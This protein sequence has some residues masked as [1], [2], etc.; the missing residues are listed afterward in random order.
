MKNSKMILLTSIFFYSAASF[1]ASYEELGKA[2]NDGDVELVKTIVSSGIDINPEC[3]S[4]VICRPIAWAVLSNNLDVIIALHELGADPNGENA[5]GDTSLHYV[6]EEGFFDLL[7][8]LMRLGG[9]INKPNSFGISPFLAIVNAGYFEIV[10]FLVSN[11][12]DIN[13]AH[14]NLTSSNMASYY[15][16]LMVAALNGHEDVVRLLIENGANP[17]LKNS[18]GKTALD[19]ASE[20]GHRSLIEILE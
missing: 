1:G 11:G 4:N 8:P 3:Q 12:A 19:L 14:Q 2:I 10:E 16:P 17:E 9:D 6:V 13:Q 5:Y 15:T 20:N 7:R 18:E